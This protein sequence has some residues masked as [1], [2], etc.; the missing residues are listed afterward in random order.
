MNK[1]PKINKAFRD[2]FAKIFEQKFDATFAKTMRSDSF[3]LRSVIVERLNRFLDNEQFSDERKVEQILYLENRFDDVIS[4][5]VGD[6]KFRYVV[7]RVDKLKD[8]TVMIVDYKT[9]STDSLPKAIEQIRNLTLSR[10]AVYENIKSFQVPLYFHYLSKQFPDQ[11]INAALYN[12][13]TLELHKF[14]GPKVLLDRQ[15]INDI[16]LNALNFIM[17]EILDPNVSFEEDKNK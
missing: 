7:D 1:E 8:G 11:P 6:M 2:H 9:G 14:I 12:L 4:L 16:F 13:R 15:K 17:A 5:P 10:E 3:L